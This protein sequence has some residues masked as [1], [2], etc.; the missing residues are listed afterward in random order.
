[1]KADPGNARKIKSVF[2]VLLLIIG[3]TIV[4]SQDTWGVIREP[5]VRFSKEERDWLAAH[6][7]IIAAPDPD[8]PPVEY[9][10]EK[11]LYQGIAADYIALIE[12]RLKIQFKIVHL[13]NWDEVLEKALTREIDMVTAAT[14]TPQREKYLRF[15]SSF[16][17]LPAAIIVRQNVRKNLAMNDL[18]G[19]KVTT[20]YR[21]AGHDYISNMY[22][23]MAL[24]LVP[25]VQTG[26]RKVSFGMV[27][28]MVANIATASYNIEKEKI[29]NLRIAGESGFVYRLAFAPCKGNWELNNILEKGMALITPEEKQKIYRKWI[30][31]QQ[32]SL[33]KN[34]KFW[35]SIGGGLATVLLFTG[36]ILAWNI[37]LRHRVEEKTA[38]LKQK[39][40]EHQIAEKTIEE[41][42]TRYS[43]IIDNTR[44]GVAVLKAVDGGED[45]IF[46]DFNKSGETI[47]KLKRDAV[48]GRSILKV[49]PALKTFGL[50][51]VLQGVWRTGRP[52]RH[53]VSLYR[54]NRISVWRDTFVFKLPCSEIVM[55]YSD[56][57][58]L[59]TLQA[60]TMRANHLAS[61]GELAAGVAH[62]INN[63]AN[64]VI[65]LAQILINECAA[66]SLERDVAGRI[67]REGNR[68]ADIV[69]S[70]LAFARDRKGRKNPITVRRVM[71]E[72]LALTQA[73][74]QKDGVDLKIDV[75]EDL[76]CF[77]GHLQQMQQVFLNVINNA[78]YALNRKYP[79][80][81][82]NKILEILAEMVINDGRAWIR[83]TFADRG[84]GIPGDIIENVMDPFF[85]TKPAGVGTGLGLS[86]GH[87]IVS[88]HGGKLRIESN[89]GE[90]T[91]II[92]DLPAGEKNEPKNSYC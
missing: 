38:A 85:T 48:I 58:E 68:I 66:E 34:R 55:I 17:E 72:T 65:N 47:D 91:R 82:E 44:N 67:V 81:H 37:S 64:S 74:I 62:E 83:V 69:G 29:T 10:D 24:D 2:P 18:R 12:K 42:K 92:I 15:T 40:I 59:K 46:L 79:G 30:S 5:D 6:P 43:Q 41:S 54:D 90:Y 7:V 25:D 13:K 32:D 60:E 3:L 53:P 21:Y 87:G 52:V 76:P 49:F 8:F 71:T 36:G 75:A 80:G 20:V 19:M 89:D 14:P 4:M 28:A 88:D 77:I 50:F 61:I 73:Q 35:I 51:E 84:I 63:P 70:L 16:I 86:I 39:V 78:R 33:L 26:L 9:Y 27:D 23:D 56:E 1:M 31:L 57:T 22:P 11:G 45:F